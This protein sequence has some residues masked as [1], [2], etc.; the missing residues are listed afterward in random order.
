M[1]FYHWKIIQTEQ[2]TQDKSK[3][4]DQ[5]DQ[6]DNYTIGYTIILTTKSIIR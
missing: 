3:S 1:L 5:R 4:I 6:R 2:E